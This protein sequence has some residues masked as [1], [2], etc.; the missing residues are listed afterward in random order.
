MVVVRVWGGV[1]VGW[2]RG[3]HMLQQPRCFDAVKQCIGLILG[4]CPAIEMQQ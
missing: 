1:G 3:Y 2:G 4:L